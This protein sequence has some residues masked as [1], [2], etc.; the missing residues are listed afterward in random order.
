MNKTEEREGSVLLYSVLLFMGIRSSHVCTLFLTRRAIAMWN[1][2][3]NGKFQ[4]K[5]LAFPL[6]MGKE[7]SKNIFK[8]KATCLYCTDAQLQAK[9]LRY[10]NTAL[11]M[12]ED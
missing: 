4:S 5:I 11:S 12:R 6:E 8:S 10:C 2:T 9:Y 1:V 7:N 3:I